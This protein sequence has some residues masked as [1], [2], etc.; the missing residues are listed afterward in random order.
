[1]KTN[2]P[3]FHGGQGVESPT[4]FRDTGYLMYNHVELPEMTMDRILDLMKIQALNA[5]PSSA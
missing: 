2:A 4:D 3:D 5:V 1:M